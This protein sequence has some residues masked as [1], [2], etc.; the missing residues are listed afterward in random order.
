MNL[1]KE[2]KPALTFLAKFL[3]LYVI[4]NVAYGL[5]VEAY[6]FADPITRWVTSQCAHT[7]TILSSAVSV[8]D[9]QATPTVSIV[10]QGAVVLSV[11]E[12]CNGVNV[13]IIFIAFLVAFGGPYAKLLWF[14]PVGLLLIHLVNL[15]RI[16]LLFFVSRDYEEYFYYVHKF[17]FT[18]ILYLVV[19]ALWAVW[20]IRFNAKP[21]TDSTP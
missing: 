5:F 7:I 8:T 2:F 12:G 1:F 17:F 4:G 9:G 21:T 20:V 18:I 13:M 16:D 14:A 10:Q 19:F 15:L 11:Y 6:E 3:G